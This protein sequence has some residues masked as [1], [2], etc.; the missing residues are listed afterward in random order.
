MGMD[1]SENRQ[2]APELNPGEH[3]RGARLA[4]GMTLAQLGHRTGYSAAQVSRL[5][6]GRTPLTDPTVLGRFASALG[7]PPQ[8]LRSP[9]APFRAGADSY[10]SLPV[11]GAKGVGSGENT[12]MHRRTL[13]AALT[14]AAAEAASAPLVGGSDSGRDGRQLRDFLVAGVRD[15]MLGLASAESALP[16]EYVPAE[17]ARANADYANTRYRSLADRLPRVLRAGHQAGVDQYEALAHSYLLATRLLIKLH[18]PQL[19]WMAAD[20]ARQLANT[21]GS[22]L[23]TAEAARQ[24]AV[25]ARQAGWYDQALSLALSAADDPVLGE[26]G[27]AGRAQKGLLIQCAAFTVAHQGDRAGMRELTGEAA[28]IADGLGRATHLRDTAGGFTPATV[29]LHLVSAEY[30]CGDPAAAIAVADRL[31]PQL[32]PTVERRVRYHTDRATA[33]AQ[34]GRRDDCVHELLVAERLAPE[35]THTRPAV[36]AL[37][38]GLLVTGQPPLELRALAA[39]CGVLA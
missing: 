28:S 35:E 13:L 26:L 39:R 8:V 37:L 30:K 18:E 9:A 4:R 7:I 25:L 14:A 15:A 2:T 38:G 5:E 6:R 27:N 20:R 24:Q 33:Y 21:A 31:L 32:L 29:Q 16:P 22:S 10:P 3:I 1:A 12:Q 36:R 23:V 11:P 17:L 34:W 19:G